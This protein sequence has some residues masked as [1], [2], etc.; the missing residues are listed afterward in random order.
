[1]EKDTIYYWVGCASNV[2]FVSGGSWVLQR[3]GLPEVWPRI[4]T[5]LLW[6][7]TPLPCTQ[8]HWV[9]GRADQPCCF[10]DSSSISYENT[11]SFFL[12][13][14]A[15]DVGVKSSLSHSTIVAPFSW[16]GFCVVFFFFSEVWFHLLPL[17]QESFKTCFCHFM[18]F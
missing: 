9:G 8:N 11:L 14:I 18:G 6:D 2:R 17:S 13:F 10:R 3:V 7:P 12:S 4:V 16:M 1:M 15:I 5:A